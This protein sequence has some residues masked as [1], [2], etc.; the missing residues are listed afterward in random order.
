MMVLAPNTHYLKGSTETTC[1][2]VRRA[3]R[4]GAISTDAIYRALPFAA[5]DERLGTSRIRVGLR[6]SRRDQHTFDVALGRAERNFGVASLSIVRSVLSRVLLLLLWA[7]S[8]RLNPADLFRFFFH[9]KFSKFD[10][11][12]QAACLV[13]ARSLTRMCASQDLFFLF[14]CAPELQVISRGGRLNTYTLCRYVHITRRTTARHSM[15][16]FTRTIEGSFW[17]VNV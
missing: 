15:P 5:D 1:T 12:R 10:E 13:P 8:W 11:R 3:P 16:I 6:S 4:C 2:N 17:I 9:Q 14:V 7:A